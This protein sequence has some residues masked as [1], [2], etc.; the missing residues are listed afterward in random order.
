MILDNT[1]FC[2]IC[3]KPT[4]NREG[5]CDCCEEERFEQKKELI[6]QVGTLKEQE[7]S[8]FLE[9]FNCETPE[10]KETWKNRFEN[11]HKSNSPNKPSIVTLNIKP[12][13]FYSCQFCGTHFQGA[14]NLRIIQ[15]LTPLCSKRCEFR[16]IYKTLSAYPNQELKIMWSFAYEDKPLP[17]TR[18]EGLFELTKFFANKN[19]L[20]EVIL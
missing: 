2:D 4:L 18:N 5:L 13:N 15:G 12:Q 3:E 14:E 8:L 7:E 16:L 20:L 11:F 9:Q 1:Y 17:L 10:E 6:L 19:K